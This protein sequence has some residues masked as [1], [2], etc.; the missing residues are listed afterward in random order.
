MVIW[1]DDARY[2]VTAFPNFKCAVGSEYSTSSYVG[3][4]V[5]LGSASLA[6]NA[7]L[8]Y[9]HIDFA[10]SAPAELS[11]TILGEGLPQ[12]NGV[13]TLAADGATYNVR[14]AS[15]A[16]GQ[17][18]FTRLHAGSYSLSFES[19]DFLK[20]NW[21]DQV[22]DDMGIVSGTSALLSLS[23][24]QIL[25][26][27]SPDLSKGGSLR[28]QVS[29]HSTPA[30]G[31]LIVRSSVSGRSTNMTVH[32]G[33]AL[34]S[35]I[36]GGESL[37]VWF[38]GQ[39]RY[40]SEAYQD[41]A[42]SGPPCPGESWVPIV[43]GSESLISM[44]V[45]AQQQVLG[46]VIDS[47]TGL[48]VP[49]IEVFCAQRYQG[50]IIGTFLSKDVS[51]LTDSAGSYDLG[52]MSPGSC[53]MGIDSTENQVYLRALYPDT[54]C[55]TAS[56]CE[57]SGGVPV[58]IGPQQTQSGIQIMAVKGVR[59]DLQGQAL[60][61]IFTSFRYEVRR[62][63]GQQPLT[64]LLTSIAAPVTR[65]QTEVYGAG[66]FSLSASATVSPN[67]DPNTRIDF[68][69]RHPGTYLLQAYCPASG[70][71]QPYPAGSLVAVQVVFDANDPLWGDGFE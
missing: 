11:G 13:A 40:Y 24:G 20:R 50:P 69:Y 41:V 57:A 35:K 34:L 8:T 47:D 19:P 37:A 32:Q 15:D 63:G 18:A 49:G 46:T 16:F 70:S 5:G 62:N 66:D 64:A 33:E 55:Q 7:G 6:L 12:S 30:S 59:F 52:G 54:Q 38:D 4:C 25:N 2:P 43:A 42:C 58:A 26:V 10:V 27:G 71:A 65:L 48:G 17:F 14:A 28:V 23:T 1:I 22:V 56:Q 61:G 36:A 44:Q 3:Q 67:S 21:P 53:L 31:G 39:N 51:V 45:D 68:C 9:T 29:R 60:N